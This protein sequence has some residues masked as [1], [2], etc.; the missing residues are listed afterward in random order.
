MQ[1]EA[2]TIPIPIGDC[3]WHRQRN[4]SLDWRMAVASAAAALA[5]AR[6]SPVWLRT[7][8][9]PTTLPLR[10]SIV[11]YCSS[12]S[13]ASPSSSSSSCR[14]RKLVLYSKPGCC[15]CDGLKEKLQA[16]FLLSGPDSLHDVHLQVRDITTNPQWETAY[17]YEIPVLA[18]V[19]PDGTEVP[20]SL[21]SLSS[22]LLNHL[23]SDD[24]FEALWLYAFLNFCG[25]GG[26]GIEVGNSG[27]Y[28][29]LY[30]VKFS[31]NGWDFIYCLKNY[32]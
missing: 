7:G 22:L 31:N 18:K 8:Q 11:S 12:S 23:S 9:R 2:S 6:P 17:Q 19:L 10:W 21:S 24:D 13:S 4:I 29:H 16:A 20:L 32:P 1:I 25:Q 15:L 14:S 27:V 3:G 30:T 26:T 28:I 5:A